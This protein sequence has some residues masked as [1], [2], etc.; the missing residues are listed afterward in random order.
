MIDKYNEAV[1]TALMIGAEPE[2]FIKDRQASARAHNNFSETL[3]A[4]MYYVYRNCRQ[5]WPNI[6]PV[7]WETPFGSRTAAFELRYFLDSASF[8]EQ[9]ESRHMSSWTD[10]EI[11]K[12]NLLTGQA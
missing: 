10:E 8:I 1:E 12:Y 5:M 2:E 11:K 4:Q 7:S 3:D 9:L 6:S